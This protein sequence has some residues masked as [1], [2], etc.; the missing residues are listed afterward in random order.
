MI[1][2]KTQREKSARI[3]ERYEKVQNWMRGHNL[4][5]GPPSSARTFDGPRPTNMSRD[6]HGKNP[7]VDLRPFGVEIPTVGHT[8]MP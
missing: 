2:K 6:L 5:F 1:R 4:S 8:V 3:R 7:Q